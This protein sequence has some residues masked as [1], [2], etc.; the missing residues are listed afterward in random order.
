MWIMNWEPYYYYQPVTRIGTELQI[1]GLRIDNDGSVIFRDKHDGIQ[2]DELMNNVLRLEELTS[3]T[4]QPQLAYYV[5]AITHRPTFME[6]YFP[7]AKSLRKDARRQFHETITKVMRHPSFD[8]Q[9]LAFRPNLI[10][11]HPDFD[12]MLSNYSV[13]RIRLIPALGYLVAGHIVEMFFFRQAILDKLLQGT[14]R[15][16]LYVDQRSFVEDGGVAGGC[17]NPQKGCIQLVVSRLFEG[18]N[19]P[20]PGAAP[21]IHEFGHLL[22]YFDA[23]ELKASGKS[24]GWLP[25]MRPSDGAIYSP[26]AREV[27]IAGKRLE[28]ERYDRQ[29]ANPDGSEPLPIGHPYVFQSNSEFIAGYLE[30]FFRNPHYFAAQN[31]DLFDGFV[32]LFK[33]DPRPYWAADFPYYVHQNRA[34]YLSG[35][36]PRASGLTLETD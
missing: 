21:F 4:C 28:I 3:N 2:F 9:L 20:T 31:P 23:G 19:Q 25:G 27:F 13:D 5:F 24:S 33:Q 12:L 22:D 6:S 34:F 8:L 7:I 35:Q 36:R 18:F 29:V 11:R 16:W 14:I 26:E 32:R 10:K 30:M 1:A 15:I 17:Y